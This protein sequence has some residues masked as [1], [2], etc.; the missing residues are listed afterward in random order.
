MRQIK[1]RAKKE[2][3]LFFAARCDHVRSAASVE[4]LEYIRADFSLPYSSSSASSSSWTL[5]ILT[6]SST[7]VTDDGLREMPEKAQKD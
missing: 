5:C 2:G 4:E 7:G 1:K 6:P 3:R